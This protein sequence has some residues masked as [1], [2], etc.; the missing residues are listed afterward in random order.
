MPLI[1]AITGSIQTSKAVG[2]QE[3]ALNQG[4]Q[5]VQGAVS[6]GQQGL[7]NAYNTETSNLNPY[8]SAGQQGITSLASMLQ[9]GGALTQQFTAPTLA[10]AQATP[11]YQFQQQQGSQAVQRAAAANGQSLGGATEAAIA[12]YTQGLA[13]T[14]YNNLY[15]QQ[16]TTFQTNRNNTLQPLNTLI[17]VGQNATGQLNQAAQNYGNTSASFGLQGAGETAQLLNQ[18]G[19]DKAAGSVAQGNIWGGVLGGAGTGAAQGSTGGGGW[20]GALTGALGSL[21]GI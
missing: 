21:A 5:G 17:G 20:G 13:D 14:T 4:I 1:S 12:Q 11:G 18:L 8:L 2:A 15:N 3:N 7:T 6:T 16:L 9:P 10:Q 19:N